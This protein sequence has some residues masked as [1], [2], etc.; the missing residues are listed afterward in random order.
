MEIL[1][2]RVKSFQ[3]QQETQQ[4][5]VVH[6]CSTVSIADFEQV[7]SGWVKGDFG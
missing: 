5:D 6:Y 7:I 2:K 3:S 1:E 4:N